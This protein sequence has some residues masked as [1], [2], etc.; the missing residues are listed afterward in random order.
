MPATVS[1]L[2]VSFNSGEH[3]AHTLSKLCTPGCGAQV[4]VWDNGSG[5]STPLILERH[6]DRVARLGDGRNYGYAYAVNR[7]LSAAT[8]EWWLL[9]NGDVIVDGEKLEQMVQ[10]AKGLPQPCLVGFGQMN[11]N[12]TP[13]LTWGNRPRLATEGERRRR[14]RAFSRGEGAWP[15]ESPMEVDWL[16]GSLVFGSRE[17]WRQAGDWDEA[18]FLFFEDAEFCL[19]A[20]ERGVR[21]FYDGRVRVLHG[22]GKSM[23]TR[24]ALAR[25]AYRHA[26]RIYWMRHGSGWERLLARLYLAGWRALWWADMTPLGRTLLEHY[27]RLQR[28]RPGEPL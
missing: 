5:D 26:Q 11:E 18:Y 14:T 21:I 28:R 12:G 24:P 3:L 8:G 13:Q 20:K 27:R 22:H 7:L 25:A 17:S 6:Q 16:S 10:A 23:E 9:I 15:A 1:V 2:I 19:S 4:L